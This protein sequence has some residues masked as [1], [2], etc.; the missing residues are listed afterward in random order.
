MSFRVAEFALKLLSNMRC[1]MFQPFLLKL[2][3]LPVSGESIES[4]TMATQ[5]DKNLINLILIHFNHKQVIRMQNQ[6]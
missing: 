6:I 3:Q 5:F 1:G 4:A 2:Q